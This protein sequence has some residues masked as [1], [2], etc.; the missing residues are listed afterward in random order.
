MAKFLGTIDIQKTLQQQL[1]RKAPAITFI[2]IAYGTPSPT[3]LDGADTPVATSYPG[4]GIVDDYNVR[5]IDN[6]TVM[7]GDRKVLV[8]VGSLP[9]AAPV[10]K[11]QDQVIAEGVTYQIVGVRRD[12]A[13]ATYELQVRR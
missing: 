8:F 2:S 5:D 1:G 7:A 6:T 12:P 13:A 3:N 10:P 9:S 11:P 4:N